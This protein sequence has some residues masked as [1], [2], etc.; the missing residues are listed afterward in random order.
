MSMLRWIIKTD[1]L[2]LVVSGEYVVK[3][4]DLVVV[5]PD[6]MVDD[7]VDLKLLDEYLDK[8]A[9]RVLIRR[10]QKKKKFSHATCVASQ[11]L[12][13][14]FSVTPASNGIITPACL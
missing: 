9:Q 1:I 5:M 4:S 7:Q 12:S 6:S 13:T 3:V 2:P 14:L 8:T 11:R 10:I